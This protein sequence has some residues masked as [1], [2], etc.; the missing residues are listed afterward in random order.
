[1]MY[2]GEPVLAK[3]ALEIGLVNACVPGQELDDAVSRYLDVL[4]SRS[5]SAARTLKKVVYEGMESSLLDGLEC[6]RLALKTI[7]GSPDY[8]EGLAAFAEKRAP[9]FS[10]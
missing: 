2:T 3:N 4:G 9:R 5:P 1:M 7:L 10:R 6:E 8:A